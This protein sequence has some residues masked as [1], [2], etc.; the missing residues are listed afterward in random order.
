MSD[1]GVFEKLIFWTS[2]LEEY[3][4]ELNYWYKL[5]EYKGELLW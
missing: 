2:N 3:K 5:E 1:R 4:G